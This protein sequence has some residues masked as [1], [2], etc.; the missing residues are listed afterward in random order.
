MDPKNKSVLETLECPRNVSLVLIDAENYSDYPISQFEE[1]NVLRELNK[2]L[3]AFR[4]KSKTSILESRD[5]RIASKDN[6][7]Q[8]RFGYIKTTM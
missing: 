6:A 3:L 1:D 8:R 2:C 7:V 5:R 4:Q